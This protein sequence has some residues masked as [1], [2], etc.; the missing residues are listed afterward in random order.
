M[1]L[2]LFQIRFPVMAIASILH[3]IS[4]VI[5]FF[6]IPLML[7]ALQTSLHTASC[8]YDIKALFVSPWGKLINWFLLSA[9]IYHSVAGIRHLVMDLGYGESIQIGRLTARFVIGLSLILIILLG[10]QLW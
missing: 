3:R 10:V 1:F 7:W 9:L 2:N 6:A 4:G 5:L 8:Y